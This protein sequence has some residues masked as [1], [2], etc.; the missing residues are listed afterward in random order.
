MKLS[1]SEPVEIHAPSVSFFSDVLLVCSMQISRSSHVVITENDSTINAEVI[2]SLLF[3]DIFIA[4]YLGRQQ[5]M[6]T[7]RGTSDGN[8]AT[9]RRTFVN[10]M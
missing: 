8:F 6:G 7:G 2:L 10:S 9:W 5:Q 1:L 3:C 4:L